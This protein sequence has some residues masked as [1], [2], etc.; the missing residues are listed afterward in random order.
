MPQHFVGLQAS[1]MLLNGAKAS[2]ETLFGSALSKQW[3]K[4]GRGLFLTDYGWRA[5]W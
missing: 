1:Q 4:D 2:S 3:R 5:H